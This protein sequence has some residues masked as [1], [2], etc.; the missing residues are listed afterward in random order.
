[1][2]T[3]LFFVAISLHLLAKPFALFLHWI[4]KTK[5]FLKNFSFKKVDHD[6]L[7][8]AIEMDKFCNHEDAELL[9]LLFLTEDSV[10]PFG[11][12]EETISS[13]LGKNFLAGT[14]T[15]KGHAMCSILNKMDKNHVINSIQ[16][17]N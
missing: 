17:F 16:A 14:L 8:E 9:T 7:L 1:M 3:A 13:V 11:N 4:R 6:L 5:L 15:E 10:H 12:I 2:G